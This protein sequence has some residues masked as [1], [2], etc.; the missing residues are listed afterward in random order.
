MS[1]KS[2]GIIGAGAV[3]TALADL[4]L[5]AGHDICGITTRTPS[6]LEKHL[7]LLDLP[8]ERG[9]SSPGSWCSEADLLFITVPDDHISGVADHIVGKGLLSDDTLSALTLLSS[10][11][12]LLKT[13]PGT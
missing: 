12:P 11:L 1:R 7:S 13:L 8:P 6:S 2:I 4:I 5:D 3:G 10:F 9:F